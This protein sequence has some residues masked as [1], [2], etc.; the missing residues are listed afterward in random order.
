MFSLWNHQIFTYWWLDV[1]KFPR[2]MYLSNLHLIH[3]DLS[4]SRADA[5]WL[6]SRVRG[7]WWFPQ[8]NIFRESLIYEVMMFSP[9]PWTL[10]PVPYVH[11]WTHIV[12]LPIGKWVD[13]LTCLLTLTK[14]H[15]TRKNNQQDK[16]STIIHR[17]ITT[18]IGQSKSSTD[19]FAEVLKK[20]C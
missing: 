17:P 11:L 9:L 19:W 8:K 1:I 3:L 15:N 16:K 20:R 14:G 4:D 10:F 12:T 5:H 18:K 2:G 13:I 6:K 7:T